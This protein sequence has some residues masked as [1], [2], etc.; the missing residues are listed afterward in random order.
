MK[1][2][3]FALMEAI[4]SAKLALEARLSQLPNGLFAIDDM[5]L[6]YV[7]VVGTLQF[8]GGFRLHES[9]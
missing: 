3:L 5:L 4:Q 7:A 1:V 9:R 8:R 6:D 2:S